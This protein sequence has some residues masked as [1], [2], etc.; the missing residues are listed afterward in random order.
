MR[1]KRCTYNDKCEEVRYEYNNITLAKTRLEVDIAATLASSK[2]AP[3]IQRRIEAIRECRH[4]E[5]GRQDTTKAPNMMHL[6]R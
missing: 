4:A 5:V 1:D 2:E 6:H 3:R